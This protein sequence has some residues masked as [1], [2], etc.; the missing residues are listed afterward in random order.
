[1]IKLSSPSIYQ[2]SL[3]SIARCYPFLSGAASIPNS[4]A[5]RWISGSPN[6]ADWAPTPGGEIFARLNDFVGRAVFFAGDLDPKLSL[7]VRRLL[8]RGDTVFDIGANIGIMT[9]QFSDYV[10]E[11]GVVHSFEPNPDVMK[12]LASAVTRK[13]ASNVLLNEIA[14]GRKSDVLTLSAP[15]GNVGAGSLV[16]GSEWSDAKSY[17]VSVKTLDEYV[18]ERS[19]KTIDLIKI[20]VEGGELDLFIGAR[21]VLEEIEPRAV[22]FEDND[23]NGERTSPAMTLLAELGYGFISVE[24][25]MLTLKLSIF[26]PDK[27][28]VSGHDF[29]AAKRGPLF[30]RLCETLGLDRS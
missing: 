24:K 10:G 23:R 17:L 16:R 8:K 3:A 4:R 20:D 22:L 5:F 14:L 7:I 30:K 1:M 28:K 11:T 21:H 12:L 29:V 27:E 26:D 9:L 19:I 15:E 18:A 2:K 6:V 25:S 13:A